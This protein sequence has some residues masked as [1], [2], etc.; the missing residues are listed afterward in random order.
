MSIFPFSMIFS[1]A[2]NLLH[3]P[4]ACSHIPMY[5]PGSLA[6]PRLSPSGTCV[7]NNAESQGVAS[8]RQGRVYNGQAAK[9]PWLMEVFSEL[10]DKNIVT[11]TRNSSVDCQT[12][13][14]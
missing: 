3:I 14:I 12:F 5:W 1:I 9:Q 10:F 6:E 13:G 8:D 2:M 4:P 11:E 7:P